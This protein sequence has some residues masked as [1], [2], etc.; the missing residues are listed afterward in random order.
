MNAGIEEQVPREARIAL[1]ERSRPVDTVGACVAEATIV[2]TAGSGEEDRVTVRTGYLVTICAVL[3][4]PCPGALG[5]EF[6]HLCFAWHA[7][8]LTHINVSSIVLKIKNGLV[9]YG[10]IITLCTV[11]GHGII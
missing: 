4:G 3:G 9:V 1:A 8:I 7:P 5:L 2:A 11:L 6:A 10:A